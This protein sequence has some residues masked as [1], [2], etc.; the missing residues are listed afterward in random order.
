[1]DGRVRKKKSAKSLEEYKR[2]ISAKL[3]SVQKKSN[4]KNDPDLDLK[5]YQQRLVDLT[6]LKDAKQLK[7]EFKLYCKIQQLLQKAQQ[8]KNSIPFD[9]FGPRLQETKGNRKKMKQVWN[10]LQD[11]RTGDEPSDKSLLK[12]VK[13]VKSKVDAML[14]NIIEN[15]LRYINNTDNKQSI[16]Y[17]TEQTIGLRE[18]YKQMSLVTLKDAVTTDF[19]KAQRD[20]NLLHGYNKLL[21]SYNNDALQK[22]K[23]KYLRTSKELRKILR[24]QKKLERQSK[25]IV[26]DD[27]VYTISELCKIK[28]KINS[29]WYYPK[30]TKHEKVLAEKEECEKN[31]RYESKT[32][33]ELYMLTTPVKIWNT[34]TKRWKKATTLPDDVLEKVQ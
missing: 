2:Q 9:V 13:T 8:N 20:E 3:D 7:R 10:V 12:S 34:E 25:L 27:G 28:K 33:N 5:Y 22:K 6:T 15:G 32:N 18:K 17:Y 30:N 23:E 19:K 4:T 31:N 21:N 1:M 11:F 24:V 14:A 29:K 26:V 16:L